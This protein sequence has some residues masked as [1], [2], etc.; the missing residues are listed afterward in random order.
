V[1]EIKYSISAA[2]PVQVRTV[3]NTSVNICQDISQQTVDMSGTARFC[4]TL[5]LENA[6][7]HNSE[8]TGRLLCMKPIWICQANEA[9]KE[10]FDDD[11]AEGS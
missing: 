8:E 7:V 1:D 2:R 11:I 10:L 5:E 4:A 6:Y 9:D 3:R